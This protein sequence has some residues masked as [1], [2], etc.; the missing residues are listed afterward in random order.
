M[1][2][3]RKRL[4]QNFST[5]QNTNDTLNTTN[6]EKWETIKNA[7]GYQLSLPSA[8][9]DYIGLV[10]F[11]EDY[12]YPFVKNCAEKY[13]YILYFAKSNTN[14]LA[15]FYDFF[16]ACSL[17]Y[18]IKEPVS[19]SEDKYFIIS[20]TDLDAKKKEKKIFTIDSKLLI[21][22]FIK[23]KNISFSPLASSMNNLN[24]ISFSE[25]LKTKQEDFI[26][27]YAA[28]NRRLYCLLFQSR[29]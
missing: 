6:R 23:E 10:N 26:L 1:G 18:K 5:Q 25:Y 27:K 24:N 29:T 11:T 19:K 8:V 4:N 7:T 28:Y 14:T 13:G 15:L 12:Y 17:P 2:K 22:D 21:V 3:K 9:Y 16:A 20:K